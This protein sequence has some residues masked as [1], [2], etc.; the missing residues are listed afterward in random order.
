MNEFEES[1]MLEL[2][3]RQVCFTRLGAQA[4]GAGW[5]TL[6]VSPG[7]DMSVS[8]AYSRVENGNIR[9]LDHLRF[10][11][12][13][14][15]ELKITELRCDEAWAFLSRIQCGLT[16]DF[17]RAKMFA[18]GFAFALDQLANDPASVLNVMY[19]NFAFTPE[20]T[21]TA[22]NRFDMAPRQSL[23]QVLAIAGLS[24]SAYRDLVLGMYAVMFGGAKTSLG[25]VCDCSENTI[26]AVM[27]ALFAA[28]PKPLRKHLSFSTY[29]T[30]KGNP[31]TVLF[32]HPGRRGVR[33][34][35]DLDS[36]IGNAVD[37]S[38]RR[39]FGQY[40]IA[41]YAAEHIGEDI[42]A[43]FD[44]LIAKLSAL[45]VDP[46]RDLGTYNLAEAL[47]YE[48]TE[49]TGFGGSVAHSAQD[50]L[51]RLV[52]VLGL[53]SS[54]GTNP[55]RDELLA[56]V[57]S[58]ILNNNYPITE[59]IDGPLARVLAASTNKTL[60]MLGD[61]YVLSKVLGKAHEESSLAAAALLANNYP[62]RK[63]P[64]FARMR[65]MLAGD[66][67][68]LQVLD[69]YYGTLLGV[70]T[71]IPGIEAKTVGV[72]AIL[73][74]HNEVADLP[75]LV[76]TK[77]AIVAM[78][79]KL[80]E[81]TLTDCGQVTATWLDHA[82]KVWD[83]VLPAPTDEAAKDI[84]FQ[85]VQE[86][87][88]QLFLLSDIDWANIA[89]DER[90]Y[91]G[92]ILKAN[93]LRLA[94]PSLSG[95]YR[96]FVAR[97]DITMQVRDYIQIKGQLPEERSQ[98]EQS[99]LSYLLKLQRAQHVQD[100]I[101]LYVWLVLYMGLADTKTLKLPDYLAMCAPEALREDR[102]DEALQRLWQRDRVAY[103]MMRQQYQKITAFMVAVPETL[104]I[105]LNAFEDADD[106]HQFDEGVQWDNAAHHP[107]KGHCSAQSAAE[108]V[109]GAASEDLAQLATE[110][111]QAERDRKR[112]S[113][114]GDAT[115]LGEHEYSGL[116][117]MP[118]VASSHRASSNV[119][120]NGQHM[121][122]YEAPAAVF[123]DVPQPP[124]QVDH[125]EQHKTDRIGK[126]DKA[127]GSAKGAKGIFSAMRGL[128][129]KSRQ[130]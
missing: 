2:T 36:G 57:L 38:V 104:E 89:I 86:R 48:E 68:G 69:E 98:L 101:D 45:G 6:N 88:W 16:D 34:Y 50:C 20:Q 111:K 81:I 90:L 37:D 25:I 80:I 32:A 52:D 18:H 113:I 54:G 24:Q 112:G 31:T 99:L 65:G 64:G 117:A 106:E 100:S 72:D 67:A 15:S 33:R 78:C 92:S 49:G 126:A 128:F 28:L 71:I 94:L 62:D 7:L 83:Q 60:T 61:R 46:T 55:Y 21:A 125:S 123:E 3:P 47:L 4:T 59:Q 43:H 121:R 122:A 87:Y 108:P 129:G 74:F 107:A 23:A 91:S 103:N 116:P 51:R 84:L 19:S 130:E 10:D 30:N 82:E 96:A 9:T 110:T 13:D 95:I 40:H 70:Q 17:G 53:Y 109:Y 22:P 11:S 114:P 105:V 1:A 75:N 27:L 56:G 12:E 42:D 102:I 14:A 127:G 97:T 76:K 120:R 119:S 39:R 93:L 63:V 5:Q 77:Q 8:S 58:E 79:G 35:F 73:A 41:T 26:R 29:E 44:H 124:E 85:S 118:R 115:P 66:S